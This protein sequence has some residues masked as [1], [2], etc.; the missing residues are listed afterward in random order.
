MLLE[1]QL[2]TNRLLTVQ[3]ICNVLSGLPHSMCQHRRDQI[4]WQES[5]PD[6][7]LD[8]D[9]DLD[10]II[11]DAGRCRILDITVIVLLNP[12]P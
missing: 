11:V 1:A 2:Q 10:A 3:N 8:I 6:C 9:I 5:P 12:K 7:C 4:S